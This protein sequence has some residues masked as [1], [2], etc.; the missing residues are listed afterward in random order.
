MILVVCVLG[1]VCG[2]VKE[3]VQ[4][5]IE[6]FSAEHHGHA[7]VVSF[8]NSTLEWSVA[9]GYRNFRA[10]EDNR[11]EARVDD[12]F[13]FGSVT[14]LYT[15]VA[16]MK[17]VHSKQLDLSEPAFPYVDFYL[18]SNGTSMAM[19]YGDEANNITIEHLLSMRAG[20]TEFDTTELRDWQLKNPT[21]DFTP[22]DIANYLPD[23]KLRCAP[24]TCGAYSSIHFTLLG[25]V[26]AYFD[27]APAWDKY[28]QGSAF[29]IESLCFPQHGT[30][31]EQVV[32]YNVTHGYIEASWTDVWGLSAL[33]GW[34]C[35]N[36]LTNAPTQSTFI[37]NLFSNRSTSPVISPDLVEAMLNFR[38]LSASMSWAGAYGLGVQ[39]L[40]QGTDASGRYYGHGGET[41]GFETS[42]GYND[43]LDFALSLGTNMESAAGWHL[44]TLHTDIYKRIVQD[45][46]GEECKDEVNLGCTDQ[47]GF[48]DEGGAACP[49]WVGYNCSA[50]I[51]EYDYTQLGT[52][53]LMA[54]CPDSCDSACLNDTSGVPYAVYEAGGGYFYHARVTYRGLRDAEVGKAGGT[55]ENCIT[56]CD[57]NPDCNHFVASTT[58][59]VL[60][61]LRSR[62]VFPSDYMV[63]PAVSVFLGVAYRTYFKPCLDGEYWHTG[64][65]SFPASSYTEVYAEHSAAKKE[66]RELCD[67][68]SKCRAFTVHDDHYAGEETCFLS[69][70]TATPQTV[71]PHEYAP[72]NGSVLGLCAGASCIP[73]GTLSMSLE[74][75]ILQC[76]ATSFINLMNAS[77]KAVNYN[78]ATKQCFLLEGIVTDDAVLYHYEEWYTWKKSYEYSVT[79]DTLPV[80]PADTF[81]RASTPG[82]LLSEGW[83]IDWC[84]AYHTTNLSAPRCLTMVYTNSSCSLYSAHAQNYTKSAQSDTWVWD[85]LRQSYWKDGS[86]VGCC[87]TQDGM[88]EGLSSNE[89]SLLSNR[90]V[91]REGVY[92]NLSTI[93]EPDV[94][95]TDSPLATAQPTALP[96]TTAQPTV[97]PATPTA[98]P[99]EQ[100]TVIPATTAQPTTA[101]PAQTTAQPTSGP[102]TAQP[103]G[104][105]TPTPQAAPTPTGVSDDTSAPSGPASDE[106]QIPFVVT[107]I[108]LFLILMSFVYLFYLYM[109]RGIKLQAACLPAVREDEEKLT[110]MIPVSDAVDV[111]E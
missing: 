21:V 41:Y 81:L 59:T 57:A 34:T 74:D 99:T 67:N 69:S 87:T 104:E 63:D 42:V 66:C 18:A 70:L 93:G 105:P 44:G 29:G 43:K 62:C 83:C 50:A 8:K 2:G 33:G 88:H 55:I 35:G 52:D 49:E 58:G 95:V 101:L 48:V 65:A 22:I 85:G 19:L 23:K 75:C 14:K 111:A 39:L 13:L 94:A 89:C 11:L 86:P 97:L 12:G 54:N 109:K 76:E 27:S 25:F 53:M 38:Y 60:C 100:P 7:V 51:E 103:T 84:M 90:R 91:F 106:Y 98:Q 5:A 30:L 68:S 24:G 40:P 56:A 31:A 82:V 37:Y 46:C 15:A 16:V 36:M 47:V 108:L 92:C 32:P 71:L 3:D 80:M 10:T 79:R 96:A 61:S 6:S 107:A 45:I 77:C 26:L 1:L 73:P 102:V 110:E 9:S 28:D 20:L 17:L 78:Q 72:V 4:R 64:R